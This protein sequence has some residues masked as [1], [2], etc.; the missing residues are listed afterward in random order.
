MDENNDGKLQF[1][2]VK[3]ALVNLIINLWTQKENEAVE[4][5]SAKIRADYLTTLKDE[6]K[7][8]QAIKAIFEKYDKDNNGYLDQSELSNYMRSMNLKLGLPPPTQSEIKDVFR[9]MDKNNDGKL[10]FQETKAAFVDLIIA[11][12]TKK[13]EEAYQKKNGNTNAN[14]SSQ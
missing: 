10:S 13:E 3:E 14:Q 8:D 4:D 5:R 12:W 6:E 7:I 9:T 2:E 1:S 11:L